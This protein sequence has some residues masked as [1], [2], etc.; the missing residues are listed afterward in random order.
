[1][2]RSG[3]EPFALKLLI[4]LLAVTRRFARKLICDISADLLGKSFIPTRL[5]VAEN[6][7]ELL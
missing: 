1:M 7:P 3:P 6:V 2:C 5:G 4:W